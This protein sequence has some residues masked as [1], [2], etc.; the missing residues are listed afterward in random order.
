[1]AY[2]YLKKSEGYEQNL[3]AFFHNNMDP[4]ALLV[5]LIEE[6]DRCIL[7]YFSFHW[8]SSTYMITQVQLKERPRSTAFEYSV[9]LTTMLSH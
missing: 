4:D 8:K 6:L 1:M 5:K 7:G 2:E 3:L 9:F